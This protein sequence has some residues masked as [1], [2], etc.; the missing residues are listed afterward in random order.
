MNDIAP[1]DHIP[2]RET[3][4][5]F[6]RILSEL[7]QVDLPVRHYFSPGLYAREMTIPAG[8]LLTGKIHKTAHLNTISKGKIEVW[9]EDGMRIIEAPYTFVSQ[10][11]TK[12]VGRTFEETVW[13]TYHVTE[14]TDLD[15]LEDLLTEPSD[16]L[17]ER[18]RSMLLQEE[19]S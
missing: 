15:R 12:R 13:T 9:T 4:E 6:E 14:E 8:V 18:K 19:T 7:P 1:F 2:T 10:P 11:G 3:I 5:Q 16:I 17:I